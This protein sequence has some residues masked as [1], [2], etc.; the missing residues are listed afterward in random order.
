MTVPHLARV[1]GQVLFSRVLVATSFTVGAAITNGLD[2]ALL[3]L[4]R[5][6]LAT[7]LFAPYV[8]FRHG[9]SVP[10]VAALAGYAAISASIVAFF[11]L[12]FEALR[13]TSPLNAAAI[14]TLLPGISA[15][16]A[17]L[18]VKEH[19]RGN[20]LVALGVGL[21]GALWVVFRGEPARLFSLEIGDG[22]PIFFV[23]C[24]VMGLYTPLV[25]RF[26]RGEP[27]AVM[28]FWV[29]ATG[30]GWLVLANNSA[31]WKTDWGSVE[32][33][34]YAGIAYLAVFTTLLSFFIQQH[35]T[36]HLGPTRVAA[37]GYLTPL[38]VVLIAWGG[39][40]GL[41]SLSTFFGVILILLATIA[42]QFGSLRIAQRHR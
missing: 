21:V 6:A 24:L 37:Y 19:L 20:Q 12:M 13:Q 40:G 1:H 25:K 18:I 14:Y 9:L 36:V 8:Y 22:D 10:T 35:A 3:T 27:A 33:D 11:W 29:L 28:S 5:F 16:Y 7:L 42:V 4:L 23:G 26:H 41:P 38:L 31:I 15:I 32:I 30:T 34:V 39:G 2:P 17:V